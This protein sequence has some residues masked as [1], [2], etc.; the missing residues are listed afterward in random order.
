MSEQR[1]ILHRMGFSE[2]AAIEVDDKIREISAR[3]VNAADAYDAIIEHLYLNYPHLSFTGNALHVLVG[4]GSKPLAGERLTAYRVGLHQKLIA[5]MSHPDVPQEFMQRVGQ[6][7]VDMFHAAQ[8][9][10]EDGF[11]GRFAALEKEAAERVRKAEREAV[12]AKD[13]AQAAQEAQAEAFEA[14]R[15]ANEQREHL[16]IEH[17]QLQERLA[18][19]EGRLTQSEAT[20]LQLR[21]E[22]RALQEQIERQQAGFAQ[23]L[24]SERAERARE[25]EMHDGQV[26][27]ANQ[28]IDAARQETRAVKD[29][30]AAMTKE[31][32]VAEDYQRQ[33]VSQLKGQ[34][35]RSNQA[36]EE[37]RKKSDEAQTRAD[38]VRQELEV[39]RVQLVQLGH[40]QEQVGELKA[41]LQRRND[42]I[43]RLVGA[44]QPKGKKAQQ[45]KE[46]T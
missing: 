22:L 29:Q 42:Q 9:G 41:E 6:L 40:L 37:A 23:Q 3:F 18:Q 35:E 45:P 38:T 32:T 43:D 20:C 25:R 2:T 46:G 4:R 33:L 8:V 15:Q 14:T 17:G 36:A 30:I 1:S 34:L 19:T 5:R 27:F 28:Q 39:C 31:R 10:A 21:G 24:E 13:A 7:A 11:K 44:Q 26:R 16:S 12:I